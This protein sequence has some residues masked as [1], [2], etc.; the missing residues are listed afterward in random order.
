MSVP[1]A[2]RA[3]G[4]LAPAAV[5]LA[6]LAIPQFPAAGEEP[7]AVTAWFTDAPVEK[8][9]RAPKPADAPPEAPGSVGKGVLLTKPVA[10]PNPL[11]RQERGYVSFRIQPRWNGND[12]KR[13]RILRIGDPERNG[14]LVEKAASGMLRYVMASPKKSTAARAD[15]SGWKAGQW[16]HVVVVWMDMRGN[17]KPMGLPLWID[18]VAVDGP[19]AG[20]NQ[21]LN[22]KAMADPHVW[23]GDATSDAVMDELILR[24]RWDVEQPNRSQ[25]AQVYRDYF[26]SAP[27]TGIVIDPNSGYAPAD[28]RVV[29]GHDKQ[30]TLMGRWGDKLERM[31]D[32]T[33][34]YSPWSEFD[35]KSLITWSTSDEKIAVVDPV[36]PPLPRH[37]VAWDKDGLVTGKSV[38][39]CK[40][41]A[42]FRDLKAVYD[43]EVIPIEQPDL[44]LAW[45]E[46]LPR[47]SRH[48]AK[49]RPEPGEKMR[50]VAHVMNFGYKPVPAGAE[51]RFELIP[52]ANRNFRLDPKEKPIHVERRVIA[53]A[54]APRAE[55]KL[56]F[57]W[58]W[59]ADPVWVR[60]TV[61]G[62]NKIAELCEA[63]NRRCDLNIARP[64]R[65]GYFQSDIDTCHTGRKIN[66]VGSFSF[67]DYT[68]ASA[69]RLELIV[70]EAIWPT[71][72]PHGIE[73][74]FRTDNMYEFKPGRKHGDEPF[75][76]DEAY[77]DGGW[78]LYGPSL[79]RY[80]DSGLVHEMGHGCLN[81]ADLYGHPVHHWGVLLKDEKG[82]YYGRGEL[83][84]CVN[85][86]DVVTLTSA[87]CTPCGVGHQPLMVSNHFWLHPAH[88][89]QVQWF[90]G[91]RGDRFWG[92]QGRLL[93]TRHHVL[94]V[95][96]IE[97]KPLPGAAVYVYH[98][99]Q[100]HA[101]SA[102]TKYFYDRP[103]FIGNT[104]EDGRYLM[105]RTDKDWDDPMT[106][107]VEGSIV[108]WNPFGGAKNDTAFTPNVWTVDGLLLIKIVHGGQT[109]FRWMPMT[110]LNEAFFRGQR[111]RGVYKIR[112]SLPPAPG[113]TK[114][115]RRKIPDA[116]R[117]RNLQP[118]AVAAPKTLTVRCGQA[119]TV[120]ASKSRDPEGQPLVYRWRRVKGHWVEPNFST[121]AILK[122]KAQK[123]PGEVEYSLYVIDGL[124]ASEPVIVKIKVE[125]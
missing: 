27:Y 99:A 50:S 78:R 114:I 53:K 18:K 95:L 93:A 106:D 87:I 64:L 80:Q 70:R 26:R 36:D 29:V 37:Q 123:E 102:A 52:D 71:T 91:Y 92:V 101:Q 13:H 104:D 61:D 34:R 22:P 69:Y 96:D 109:E 119:F 79:I 49:D 45:V 117:K 65:W 9:V 84:P 75:V 66:L 20:G 7:L 55:E 11:L 63:N 19:I 90:R 39:K 98:V 124:R 89:G 24:N 21:F 3:V 97:D 115:V 10:V 72:S 4:R 125:K 76:Q 86:A 8:G 62:D 122:C 15:V 33:V 116:I 111:I 30:F 25:I 5:L 110:E 44:D 88:A 81:L 14:L 121:D 100:T 74:S 32:F 113:V 105:E 108:T 23:I 40:L 107:E 2:Q 112:T 94:E 82:K 77:Y 85:D 43:L 6:W 51:V 60:V 16:H 58:T 41:T 118:V 17:G 31:T 59:T 68:Q 57:L 12:G 35:A 48:R 120:D 54:L 56:T 28:R 73:D 42:R 46:Q 83:M 1:V 47:Y 67:F 38:G 103:K